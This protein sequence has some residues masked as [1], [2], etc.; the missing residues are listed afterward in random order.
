[1]AKEQKAKGRKE[2]SKITTTEQH[3]DKLSE[4]N[5]DLKRHV[6]ETVAG[7]QFAYGITTSSI[8]RYKNDKKSPRFRVRICSLP[9]GVNKRLRAY[10]L[11]PIDGDRRDN[12]IIDATD[13][14]ILEIEK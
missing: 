4:A 9:D 13:M 14:E 2:M 8:M 11:Y 7:M 5:L 12:F 3:I 6:I 1:L 10:Y